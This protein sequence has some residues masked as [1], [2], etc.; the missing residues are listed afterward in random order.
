MIRT[1]RYAYVIAVLLGLF[2]AAL[3]A[4]LPLG[5]AS[6][7]TAIFVSAAVF[8]AVGLFLGILWPNGAWRWG[9][10][11]VAPG[12]LL[13]VVG[14]LFSQEF[15]TFLRDDLPFLV[16]GFVATCLGGLIGAR[17]SPRKSAMSGSESST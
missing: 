6:L 17:L 7:A 12:L 14:V 3:P 16:S 1:P 15:G 9:Y 2:A 8:G 5:S 11:V 10:W 13:V 4:N